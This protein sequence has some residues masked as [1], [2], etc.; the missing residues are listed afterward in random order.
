MPDD[1]I[2]VVQVNTIRNSV[3]GGLLILTAAGAAGCASPARPAFSSKALPLHSSTRVVSNLPC[4]P[5]EVATMAVVARGTGAPALSRLRPA[6]LAT[7]HDSRGGELAFFPANA[8]LG[9]GTASIFASSARKVPADPGLQSCDYLLSNRPA[10]RPF[11]KAAIAA[12]VARGLAPS[13]RSLTKSLAGIEIGDSPVAVGSLVVIL[14]VPG[15]PQGILAGHTVLGPD[16]SI[17]VIMN[18]D[19]QAI[20]GVGHGSW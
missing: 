18:R 13:T 19:N 9:S 16:S 3:I 11:V 12:A 4:K 15:A 1:P 8:G 7:V 2:G 20:T 5:A 10:A 17:F 14:L 6:P